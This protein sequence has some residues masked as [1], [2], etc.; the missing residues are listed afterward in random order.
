VSNNKEKLLKLRE[1]GRIAASVMSKANRQISKG[2]KLLNICDSLEKDIKRQNA[3][4]SFPVNISVNQI[5]AHYTSPANDDLVLPERSV[6]KIDLGAHIDGFISDHAKTFLIDP[7]K[8]YTHLKETAELALEKAIEIIEPGIKPADIG[9]VIETTIRDEGL[10]PVTDLTGHE[11]KQWQ[12]HGG[13]VIPN[14]KPKLVQ[15]F[16]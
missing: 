5:A 8:T 1:A 11:I 15:L 2:K 16:L 10:V 6:V 4:P 14:F 9:E 13:T 7:N 3:K 12:L